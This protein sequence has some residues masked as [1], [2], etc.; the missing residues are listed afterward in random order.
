[1]TTKIIKE[2]SNVSTVAVI[3]MGLVLGL[4]FGLTFMTL[5]FGYETVSETKDMACY[6]IE[7]ERLGLG[8]PF[9]LSL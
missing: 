6:S 7:L 9:C 2:K 8:Y 1:M 3:V 4:L 5:V